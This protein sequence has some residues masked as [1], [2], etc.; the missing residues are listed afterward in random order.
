[1]RN[2]QLE[3][4]DSQEN[5]Y[6][7]QKVEPAKAQDRVKTNKP[8]IHPSPVKQDLFLKD[9]SNKNKKKIT[10][11]SFSTILLVLTDTLNQLRVFFYM[12]LSHELPSARYGIQDLNSASE[13]IKTLPIINQ[14]NHSYTQLL[15]QQPRTVYDIVTANQSHLPRNTI[16]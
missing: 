11:T 12:E 6:Q 4:L 3:M 13:I 2:P 16:L 8:A 7:P 9:I 14:Q 10:C 15:S 1:M 5:I